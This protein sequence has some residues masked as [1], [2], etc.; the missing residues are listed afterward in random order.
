MRTI[1][2]LIFFLIHCLLPGCTTAPQIIAYGAS[3]PTSEH[4]ITC[5]DIVA[6]LEHN[7]YNRRQVDDTLSSLL[8]ERYLNDL[9]PS[10][11]CFCAADIKEFE[12]YRFILDDAV[13]AGNLAPAFAIY[14]C[15]QER[16]AE[17][18]T[19]IVK[20]LTSN[21]ASIR[22]DDNETLETDRSRAPWPEDR[23][24]LRHLWQKRI[25]AS[26][27]NLKLAGKPLEEA[28]R[29]L[30]QRATI[31]LQQLHQVN[32]DDVFQIFMNALTHLYDPHTEYLAPRSSE[33]FTIS[34]SLSLEG[35]GA[36]LQNDNEYTKIVSLVPGGPADASKQLKPGD[37]IIGVGE[38]ADGDII[39]VIG[40]RIDDVV[41]RIRGPKQTLVRLEI[42]PAQ[43]SDEHQTKIVT[44]MRDTIKLEHQAARTT[45]VT[46]G[47]G[48][49]LRKIGIITI[50]TFY[51]DVRGQQAHMPQYR[52]TA[53]DVR[54][55]LEQLR[56]EQVDGIVIDLRDNGGGSLQ[57]ALLLL[58]MLLPEGPLVQVRAANGEVTVLND[59]DPSVLYDGPLAIVVNRLSASASEIVAAAIQDYRRGIIIGE[60][61]F[62]KGTV[63]SL[64]TMRRG[65]LKITQAT[66]Y[67]ISGK[68]TQHAGVDPDIEYPSLL[69]TSRIGE[70]TLPHALPCDALDPVPY[71]VNTAIAA[72]VPQLQ[73]RHQE[74]MAHDPDY[75]YVQEMIA[76]LKETRHK[77]I[78]SLNEEIRR[79]EDAAA[80]QR[81]LACENRRRTAKQM[82]LLSALD[83]ATADNATDTT[84]QLPERDPILQEAGRVLADMIAL[85]AKRSQQ[86]EKPYAR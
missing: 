52:S 43:A 56:A 10:R 47:D 51:L 42:I 9:D 81:R 82:P 72:L 26:L 69:D 50:P 78:I 60:P 12:Q 73:A 80:K 40:W 58:G 70:R 3:A 61:T 5:R 8:L 54:R 53:G 65:Q 25:T 85:S 49:A 30:I 66:F 44:L 63:Q 7:H 62:G 79:R 18:L 19:F 24:A 36:V 13:H 35:I 76:F 23:R 14:K 22:F 83:N 37:R 48:T 46:I 57:E 68:S 32:S 86:T 21:S 41:Q 31:Q 17:Q 4:S 59:N 84:A 27:L 33:N 1:A 28:R 2:L 11:S 64:Q 39:N 75:Q 55:L 38:G 45:T 34:M 16:L 71:T 20:E 77:T 15:Y 67:R 74:R 6:A 29:L